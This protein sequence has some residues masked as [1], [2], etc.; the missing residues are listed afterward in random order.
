M[1]TYPAT[2]TAEAFRRLASA[3]VAFSV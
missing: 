1:Q 3:V 2:P